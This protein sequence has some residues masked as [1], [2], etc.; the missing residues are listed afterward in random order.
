[1][2]V[3][4]VILLRARKLI[5]LGTTIVSFLSSVSHFFFLRDYLKK[6]ST[7]IH[8]YVV[9]YRT[10]YLSTKLNYVGEKLNYNVINE[11]NLHK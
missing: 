4:S 9:T 1:M 3:R 8:T 6:I 11:I 2:I 5:G 10:F 7:L